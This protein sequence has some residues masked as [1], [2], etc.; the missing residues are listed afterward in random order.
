MKDIAKKRSSY[1]LGENEKALLA[2]LCS[3]LE[4]LSL[5][6]NQFS[7]RDLMKRPSN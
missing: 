2:G 6:D 4:K 7:K 5:H 1:K 3:I